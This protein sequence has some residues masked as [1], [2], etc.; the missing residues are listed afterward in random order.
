[1]AKKKS[2]GQK[3]VPMVGKASWTVASDFPHAAA[4]TKKIWTEI[5]KGSK[6]NYTQAEL[7]KLAK[8][9]AGTA[10]L[11]KNPKKNPKKKAAKK[12]T[13]KRAKKAAKKKAAKKK[14]KKKSAKK[15]ATKKS[16][17]KKKA[18]KK[19]RA[20][21]AATKKAAKGT[22]SAAQRFSAKVQRAVGKASAGKGLTPKQ[23]GS[24]AKKVRRAVG[25]K[26]K[27]GEASAAELEKLAKAA[28][29]KGKRKAA[30]RA[31]PKKRAAKKAAPK[32]ARKKAAKRAS[33]KAA[34]LAGKKKRGKGIVPSGTAGKS[35]A[36]LG[37]RNVATAFGIQGNKVHKRKLRNISRHG[38][39]LGFVTKIWYTKTEI[40]GSRQNYS[41]RLKRPMEVYMEA[42]DFN[43]ALQ[44]ARRDAGMKP[45][46]K[47][48]LATPATR[49]GV[50]M[51]GRWIQLGE[52]YR[53]DWQAKKGAK[54]NRSFPT[55]AI[56]PARGRG[57]ALRLYA[58]STNK[59]LVATYE[60]TGR[61]VPAKV[62]YMLVQPET[63]GVV[64]TRGIVS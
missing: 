23:R 19:K 54:I 35:G 11:K 48:H 51:S 40:D 57:P 8:K 43:R 34:A 37:Q 46:T 30:K 47:S 36:S 2:A 12:A 32:K 15:K 9:Y 4:I 7:N 50:S 62:R 18:A 63:S 56:G 60:G 44:T 31:A 38:V 5:K 52:I 45:A 16:A 1:M 22:R 20:K 49:K 25:G 3:L 59:R 10:P 26:G 21:K 29:P 24:V 28:L 17:P 33:P 41:H 55:A 64:S 61:S 53:F 14:A 6:R 42:A 27:P 13:K 39:R 58:D